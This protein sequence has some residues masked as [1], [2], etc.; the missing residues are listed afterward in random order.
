[1]IFIFKGFN[2]SALIN[3]VKNNTAVI[4]LVKFSKANKNKIKYAALCAFGVCLLTVALMLAGV[5]VGVEVTYKGKNIGIVKDQSVYYNAMNIATS[6]ICGKDAQ[7]AIATPK[8]GLTLTVVDRLQDAECLADT[9]IKNTDDIEFAVAL[10]IDGEIKAVVKGDRIEEYLEIRRTLF[11][12]KNAENSAQF[13]KKV[14]IE[15]GYYLKDDIKD[16]AE[17]KKVIDKLEVKTVSVVETKTEIPFKTVEKK[18][19]KQEIG[20]SKVVTA[21]CNGTNISTER[22]ENVNGKVVARE[23]IS[24]EVVSKPVDKVI[25]VGTAVKRV[26]AT[27]RAQASSAGFICPITKGKFSITAYW[28]DGRN[29]KA[30]D[31]AA[32]RGTPIFAA[33]AG[34]VTYAG[35]D[36][37]FGYNIVI[38][39]SNGMSTRY[40][41]ANALCVSVGQVVSQGD[42]IAT[43]GSTGWST[44]SHLH[45]EVIVN[46]VRVNPAPYIGM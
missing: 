7:K 33:A 22:I 17:A 8:F 32:D 35:Y 6:G 45:F 11:Y 16:F 20:Y 41:H 39:H 4:S 24:S 3:T 40:A 14:E 30:I 2:A 37:D 18:T 23:Q 15:K 5:T 43:V 34:T 26:T 25:L 12:T 31:L 1:M 9:I 21:G 29:H 42:M 19:D 46:G 38:K 44:G 13:V 28:G 36:S 10:K 27:E